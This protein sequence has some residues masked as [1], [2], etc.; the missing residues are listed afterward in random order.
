MRHYLEFLFVLEGI[1]PCVLFLRNR[2]ENCPIFSTLVID[3]LVP[4]MNRLDLWSYGFRLGFQSGEWVF[5]DGRSP[6]SAQ[7]HKLFLTD[8]VVRNQDDTGAYPNKENMYGVPNLE[9]AHALGYPVRSDGY[10]SARWIIMRDAT[11]LGVLVET[12]GWPEPYCCVQGLSFT[13]AAGDEMEWTDI[14]VHYHRCEQAAG[15]VGTELQL[16]T[17]THAEMTAWLAENPGVLEG[18]MPFLGVSGPVLHQFM[19]DL[20]ARESQQQ[21][22]QQQHGEQREAQEGEGNEDRGQEQP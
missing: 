15:A 6:A 20:Y 21:Q 14:L 4:I 1:K 3:S 22:G 13:C 17:Y 18:P 9:A 19:E 7:I 11:E 2:R 12:C 10:G 8:P 16:Y 5:Y